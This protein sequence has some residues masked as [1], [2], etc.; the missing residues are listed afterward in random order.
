MTSPSSNPG[1]AACAA[2][3]S[4]ENTPA[5]I[6]APRPITTASSIPSLR[7]R[8]LGFSASRCVRRWAV[9]LPCLA[10]GRRAN[11]QKAGTSPVRRFLLALERIDELATPRFRR[12]EFHRAVLL[13]PVRWHVGRAEDHVDER[14]E[15]REILVDALFIGRVM[16]VMELGR[17]E[18][19]ADAGPAMAYVLVNVDGVKRHENEIRVDGGRRKTENEDRQESEQPVHQRID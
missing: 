5:P 4:A 1:P 7:A 3:P 13:G 15:Y 14:Q 6:I 19:P 9:K 12:L 8:R 18:N 16:P 17:G 10:V 2:G 11:R